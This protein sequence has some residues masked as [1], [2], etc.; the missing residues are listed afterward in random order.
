MLRLVCAGSDSGTCTEIEYCNVDIQSHHI[1]HIL[2]ITIDEDS[3]TVQTSWHAL[4]WGY[5]V[6]LINLLTGRRQ[7][8]LSNLNIQRNW[9]GIGAHNYMDFC[10]G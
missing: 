4:T 10:Q 5:E 8:C 3:L 9:L 2:Q 1:K 7:S 6:G